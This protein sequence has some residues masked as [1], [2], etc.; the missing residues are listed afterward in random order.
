MDRHLGMFGGKTQS[1][2]P[3]TLL[4]SGKKDTI[5]YCFGFSFGLLC[6]EKSQRPG[7]VK[8]CSVFFCK[9]IN[10]QVLGYCKRCRFGCVWLPSLPIC[11]YLLDA[12]NN[13]LVDNEF[14]LPSQPNRM[15]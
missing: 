15:E 7:K 6:N 2:V 9:T 12:E 11:L 3:Q 10:P 8:G 13:S 5:A 4:S 1:P 14:P